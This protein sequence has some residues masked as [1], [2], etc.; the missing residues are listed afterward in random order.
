VTQTAPSAPAGV[1][2]D[3]VA[4]QQVQLLILERL[5]LILGVLDRWEK[6]WGRP[7][8]VSTIGGRKPGR[9]PGR[10]KGRKPGR[11]PLPAPEIPKHWRVQ[12]RIEMSDVLIREKVDKLWG[13]PFG[14]YRGVA[15]RK[16]GLIYVQP[17]HGGDEIEHPAD[18]W[19]DVTTPRVLVT[20]PPGGS[21]CDS[22]TTAPASRRGSDPSSGRSTS[23]SSASSPPP[24]SSAG[25]SDAA[26]GEGDEHAQ[27]R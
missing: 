13:S 23:P 17:E 11:K 8:P 14:I 25:P 10:K 12:Q 2:T 22:S 18:Y 21:T 5:T 27:A 7:M 9:K 16:A 1:R 15:N 4:V 20:P 6:S 24:G 26:A 3:P 19:K